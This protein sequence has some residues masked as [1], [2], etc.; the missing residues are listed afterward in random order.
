MVLASQSDLSV[1]KSL[2]WERALLLFAMV[3]LAGAIAS[4]MMLLCFW[5]W[6][7]Q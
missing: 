6:A 3:L 2:V 4:F 1:A 5:R 7:G